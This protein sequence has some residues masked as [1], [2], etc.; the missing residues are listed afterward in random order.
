MVHLQNSLP[1]QMASLRDIPIRP[2]SRYVNH[3]LELCSGGMIAGVSAALN[4]GVQI[5]TI[6]LVEN[7]RLVRYQ[8]SARLQR[9]QADFP[10]LLSP[11]SILHPFRFPQ[12]VNAITAHSLKDL[13]P[14]TVVFATPPCQAFSSA[15]SVPGWNSPMSVPLVSCVN[16]VRY[17][18]DRQTD[19]IT[20]FLENVPNTTSFTEVQASLGPAII[21]E[22]H[23]LGSSALRKTTI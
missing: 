22:A 23:K 1:Q 11:Q 2:L 21:L 3:W 14:V 18:H 6:S 13:P 8:A 15:G 9:L 4:N 5:N 16:L 19:G 12:D 20:S 7:N 10:H 17:L